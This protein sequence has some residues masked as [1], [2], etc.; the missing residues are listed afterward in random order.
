MARESLAG[1]LSSNERD[2]MR[3]LAVLMARAFD[4]PTGNQSAASAMHTALGAIADGRVEQDFADRLI[5]EMKTAA[6]D[7]GR[8]PQL[9]S[10]LKRFLKAEIRSAGPQQEVAHAIHNTFYQQSRGGEL[11]S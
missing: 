7:R 2:S 4:A 1:L 8:L 3:D 10:Q 9:G 11:A 5:R 6:H